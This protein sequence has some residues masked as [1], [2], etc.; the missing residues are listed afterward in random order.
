MIEIITTVESMKQAEALLPIVDT[1]YFGEETFAL[2]L[3]HSFT[4]EEQ[5]QLVALAHQAGK[6]AMIAVN[7]LMHPEKMKLIPEYLGFLKE[8][9]VDQI[10]IGE[11]GTIFV[12]KKNTD[13]QIPYIYAGETLV[14]S[15]RQINFWAKKGAVGA[16]LARE[17]PY[18]EMCLIAPQLTIPVEVLVYGGT[19]IHHSKRPLLQ[20]YYNFTDQAEGKTRKDELF[21]SE[22]KKDET[23]YSIF[24]DSH[25]THIFANNDLNLIAELKTLAE[26]GYQTWKLDGMLTPG[27]NFVEIVKLF[28]QA[29]QLIEEGAWTTTLAEELNQQVARLHPEKRGLDTGFYYVDP[30]KIK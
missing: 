11:P 10:T 4:R 8:I 14:T 17:V 25:G 23:H 13:L 26:T 5:R 20:N 24:E 3:P 21:L 15:A 28:N 30:S 9:G 1:I 18:E 22:P 7:G 2:R 29:R 12:M 19:C 6:K 16:I 27:D